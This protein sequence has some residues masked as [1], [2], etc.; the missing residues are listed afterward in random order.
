MAMNPNSQNK[1]KLQKS[2]RLYN[3]PLLASIF[4]YGKRTKCDFSFGNDTIQRIKLTC[5][6]VHLNMCIL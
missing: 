3:L 5:T 6:L 2:F 4:P 1:F